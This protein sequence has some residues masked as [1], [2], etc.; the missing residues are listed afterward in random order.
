MIKHQRWALALMLVPL[1][2]GCV[3]SDDPQAAETAD[4]NGS[5]IPEADGP[6]TDERTSS[7]N[8]T[9][10]SEPARDDTD[11]KLAFE[12][13]VEITGYDPRLPGERTAPFEP[14][15]D[16]G[17]NGTLVVAAAGGSAVKAGVSV[18]NIVGASRASPVWFSTD[19]GDNGSRMAS[20]ADV[21][22]RHPAIE[23]D[24]AADEN[25]RIY[26]VDTTGPD[27][28]F[29]RWQVEDDSP[30]WELT[31]P[32]T[33]TANPTDDRP[34]VDAAGDGHL[35]PVSNGLGPRRQ[36]PTPADPD[37]G[38]KNWIQ[39]S[40]DRG[41]TWGPPHSFDGVPDNQNCTVEAS[42]PK[43]KQA[44]VACPIAEYPQIGSAPDRADRVVLHTTSNAGTTWEREEV[45]DL[46]ASGDGHGYEA[47]VAADRDGTPLRGD[48]RRKHLGQ[49]SRRDPVRC[50]H[51]RRL[52]SHERHPFVGSLANVWAAAGD[53]GTL[54]L[55]FHATRDVEPNAESSWFTYAI[56]V[57]EADTALPAT[58]LARIDDTPVVNGSTPPGDF[59][60]TTVGPENRVVV[61]YHQPTFD[62][63]GGRVDSTLFSARQ[64][65]GPNT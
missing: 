41:R 34:W 39:T 10:G 63:N 19:D 59:L 53:D 24:V 25:G 44:Y 29:S 45:F 9:N 47:L 37:T 51:R 49:P 57:T 3:G 1:A 5:P 46:T 8:E 61:A 23:G 35:Y 16:A 6:S 30:A 17:P 65:Q 28:T 11:T 60:Q 58:Q 64:N 13:P 52:V 32:V 26:R 40:T 27:V 56:L 62:E 18:Q 7:P 55:A 36:V 20:P 54:A 48:R 33:G 2:A 15:I 22:R 38:D 43:P 42:P 14:S 4:E 21:H 31:Q 50:P 12:D